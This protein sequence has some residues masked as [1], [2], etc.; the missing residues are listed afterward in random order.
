MSFNPDLSKQAVDV[1]FSCKINPL[2]TPPVYFNN[3]A[4]ATCETHKH[5]GL[6]LDK[7]LACDCH[8]KEIS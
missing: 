8:V 7:R 6:L 4:A 3:L 2:D 5:L 1:Q